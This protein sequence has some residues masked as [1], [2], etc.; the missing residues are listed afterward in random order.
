MNSD[1]NIRNSKSLNIK[2]KN[3]QKLFFYIKFYLNTIKIQ[4]AFRKFKVKAIRNIINENDL[5]K[6]VN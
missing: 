2:D 6:N 5:P 3:R 4:R 1:I